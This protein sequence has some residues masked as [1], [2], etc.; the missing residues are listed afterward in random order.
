M[1]GAL[2]CILPF[3]AVLLLLRLGRSLLFFRGVPEIWAWLILPDGKRLPVNHWEN[4]LGSARSCDVCIP[5]EGMEKL[6]AVLARR[7]DGSWTVTDAESEGGIRV[8]G[9]K[10]KTGPVRYGQTVILGNTKVTLEPINREQELAQAE[11][12]T[13]EGGRHHAGLTLLL[14]T[15][16]QLCLVTLLPPAAALPMAALVV[17]EWVLFVFYRVIRRV[18]FEIETAAFFLYTLGQAVMASSAPEELW[19]QVLCTAMGITL[20]LCVG[21]CLRDLKR[22]RMVRYGA[23]AAGLLLLIAAMLFATEVN[24]ARNW[25]FL[26]GVSVQPSE[27]AKVCFVFVGASTLERLVTKRNLFLFLLYTG[28]VCACLAVLSD[29]GT[30]LVFFV[31]FVVIAFLRSGSF[32]TLGLICGGTGFAGFLAVRF[33]PY[34][35]KRFAAWRHVWEHA[36]TGGYQQTRAMMCIAAGGLFGLGAGESWLK[37]VAAADT[38]LVFAFVAEEYGLILAVT[39]VCTVALLALFVVRSVPFCRGSFHAIGACAAGSILL[40]QTILNVFGTVDLL[41]LTGVTFPFLSNGG[42]GMIAAW[43]LLAFLKS[44]DTRQNASFTIRLPGRNAT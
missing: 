7:D 39:A 36:Q 14:L 32:A 24:G 26:G 43:G 34:I 30:A 19:R 40:T 37:Y 23:A 33:L 15:A 22:A 29:F 4:T 16:F 31:A 10:V 18:G 35:Q 8:A 5:G 42:T 1:E 20:F 28:A 38:D 13:R 25:I 41:P 11:K 27:L 21:W 3:V 12:R 2:R 44:A 17:M 6:H 9:K